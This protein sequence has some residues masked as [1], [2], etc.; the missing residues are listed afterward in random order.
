[1]SDSSKDSGDRKPPRSRDA[2]RRT[3]AR[4]RTAGGLTVAQFRTY[5]YR[6]GLAVVGV[7]IAVLAM[8]LL[9]GAGVGVLDTGERQFEAADRDL[10]VTTGSTQITTTG[11]GGFENTIHDS[12]SLADEMETH[13][14]VRNAVPLAFDTVYVR[15][16]E[17]EEF[18]TFIGSGVAGGGA[19][20]QI[21]EGEGLRGDP[22]YA[23]GTY[24]GERTD[25]VLIDRETAD[26]LNVSVGDTL[27]IGGTL[28]AAR[29]SE[30]TVVGISPTFEGMLGAPT[31]TMPLS[32]LHQTTGTTGTEPATFVTI[33]VEEDADPLDVQADLQE[34]YPEYR[35]N[36]NEEQ[37]E[38]VLQEQVLI[39]AAAGTLVLL[40]VG[41]GI[42]LTFNL[43]SLVVYQQRR[44]LAALRAQGISSTLLVLT[45]VGQGIAIG[46]IGGALGVALTGPGVDALNRLAATVVGFDGLVQTA[47]PIYVGGFA[48][49]VC[50]GT[51]AAA[52][53]GWRVGRTPP[54]DHL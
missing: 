46:V 5:K 25:E 33:T 49:A 7:A 27:E 32:E 26:R 47:D 43:L 45:V 17:D 29:D 52:I 51:A 53:A 19:A 37:L 23:G 16:D 54:L 31:V 6:F 22:H 44:E 12:R 10:W 38:D 28:G 8:T 39:L 2:G 11:G 18:R 30:Y 1:M 15:G 4:F 35:I 42:A 36:T 40:A 14:D 41:A 21:S 9:A 24:E 13:D 50:I 20:V 3:A 48:I 34:A